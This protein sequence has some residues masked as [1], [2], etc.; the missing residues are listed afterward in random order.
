[1][2]YTQQIAA[3]E[4]YVETLN[5]STPPQ[6]VFWVEPFALTSDGVT[7]E[8]VGLKLNGDGF[9]NWPIETAHRVI[10]GMSLS[11]ML[12]ASYVKTWQK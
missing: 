6:L 10:E 2:D 4:G 1:V 12:S 7:V 8:W 9:G 11:A 5:R 3:I